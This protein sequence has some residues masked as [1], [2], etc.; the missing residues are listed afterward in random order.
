MLLVNL[1]KRSH[2]LYGGNEQC[3]ESYIVY[4]VTSCGELDN[5]HECKQAEILEV[6]E[7]ERNQAEIIAAQ[8]KITS[9]MQKWS[10]KQRWLQ[11]IYVSIIFSGSD[12]RGWVKKS[13]QK[14]LSFHDIS[15]LNWSEG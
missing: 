9:S 4:D 3:E 11:K 8:V 12:R 6:P 2:L 5:K 10:E 15:Y 1:H 13:M 7:S 14:I